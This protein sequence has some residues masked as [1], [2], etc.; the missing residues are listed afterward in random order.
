MAFADPR[1][2][3][4][5]FLTSGRNLGKRVPSLSLHDV[6]RDIRNISTK[7]SNIGDRIE[8][9]IGAASRGEFLPGQ[10]LS[11]TNEF[12][13]PPT[14]YADYF[15]QHRQP[16]FKFM[17]FVSME[18]NSDFIHAFGDKWPEGEM[19]WFIKQSSRPSVTYDYE[20][21]NMYN[22]H[23]KVLKR[24]T[25]DTM[26]MQMYDDLYDASHSFWTTYLRIQSPVTGQVATFSVGDTTDFLEESGMNWY[27]P[28]LSTAQGST[29]DQ[30]RSNKGEL[31]RKTSVLRNSASTG[32]LPGGNQHKQII[33]TIK[34]YHIIDWG[35]K[36]VVYNFINPRLTEIKLDELNWETSDPNVIDIS[37]DYDTFQMIYPN[38]VTEDLINNNLPPVYPI[39]LNTTETPLNIISKGLDVVQ[40]LKDSAAEAI[41]NVF[42]GNPGAGSG[43]GT[44]SNL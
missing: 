31:A 26:S 20:E 8:G 21:V 4:N 14:A 36:Y 30:I 13:C 5:N 41:S 17:F 7:F 43:T 19:W 38:G 2:C 18:L 44:S 15:A 24:A 29:L 25:F 42:G 12:R 37:F 33:K 28:K 32:A 11:V 40:D 3:L 1:S 6:S 34:V 10:V 23:Q 39:N 9:A 22:F 16:K 35:R 27:D